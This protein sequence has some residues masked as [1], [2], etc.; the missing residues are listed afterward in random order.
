M[1]RLFRR[2]LKD[3]GPVM[4]SVAFAARCTFSLAELQYQYPDEIQVP[5]ARRRRN[6][7]A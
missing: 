4:R 5:A 7:S 3:A 2:Y 6:S 1:E